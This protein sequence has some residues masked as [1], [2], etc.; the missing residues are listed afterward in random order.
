MR[1][2]RAIG[3]EL[4][5]FLRHRRSELNPVSLTRRQLEV[6]RLAAQGCSGREIAQRLFISQTTVKSHFQNVYAKFG[7]SDRASAVAE[8]M[9]YGFID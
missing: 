8:A 4:G 9:R 2:L 3:Y 1:S 6:I 7:V 5:Q